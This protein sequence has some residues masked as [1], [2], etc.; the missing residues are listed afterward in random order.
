MEYCLV[1]Y[2]GP[3]DRLEIT[4]MPKD[5]S[6]L[7]VKT[8]GDNLLKALNYLGIRGWELDNAIN[9]KKSKIMQF[10]FK[11][12]IKLKFRKQIEFSFI[13]WHGIGGKLECFSDNN[14]ISQTSKHGEG[15]L[16]IMNSLG[17]SGWELNNVNNIKKTRITQY[18]FERNVLQ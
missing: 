2:H 9:L 3:N 13:H 8:N 12:S 18:L 10:T 6:I 17:N 1:Y 11:R 14:V 5:T 16:K 15:L 7:T 4:P